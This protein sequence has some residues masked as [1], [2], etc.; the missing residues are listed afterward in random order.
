MGNKKPL[1]MW[2]EE[3]TKSRLL[4]SFFPELMVLEL[5]LAPAPGIASQPVAVVSS[6][7]SLNH[8]S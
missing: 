2:R 1:L 4:F 3:E 8:S 7:Q 5:D 6:G